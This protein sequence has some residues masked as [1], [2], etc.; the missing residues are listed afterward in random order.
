MT[1]RVSAG[2]SFTRD[3]IAA[4]RA[5]IEDL[6]TDLQVSVLRHEQD[7]DAIRRKIVTL[8]DRDAELAKR[9]QDLAAAGMAE[10][11][12][13]CQTPCLFYRVAA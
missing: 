7:I 1:K 2:S 10:L 4:R 12:R 13:M 8:Q 3:E 5:D 9:D 11:I 6:I